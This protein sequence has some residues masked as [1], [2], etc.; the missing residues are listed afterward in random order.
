MRMSLLKAFIRMPKNVNVAEN[1]L[2]C[3][4]KPP[5]SVSSLERLD[6]DL[7]VEEYQKKCLEWY[8]H[9]RLDIPKDDTEQMTR[10]VNSMTNRSFRLTRKLINT[11]QYEIGIPL[12]MVRIYRG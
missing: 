4:E 10:V 3:L 1:L 2:A 5:P 6:D 7:S 8:A 9:W 11:L 12:Q